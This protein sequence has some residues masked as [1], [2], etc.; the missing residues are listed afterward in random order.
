MPML[1]WV[2]AVIEAYND[3]LT[4]T[5]KGC[6]MVYTCWQGLPDLRNIDVPF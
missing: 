1:E 6:I 5:P 2:S 3:L 4:F